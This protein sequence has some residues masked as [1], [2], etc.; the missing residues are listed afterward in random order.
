[1]CT[2]ITCVYPEKARIRELLHPSTATLLVDFSTA[3]G[4]SSVIFGALAGHHTGSI[5]IKR[6]HV[7]VVHTHKQNDQ[8][9]LRQCRPRNGFSAAQTSYTMSACS[10]HWEA[11]VHISLEQR[12]LTEIQDV[13]PYG[14]RAWKLAWATVASERDILY[15]AQ[16]LLRN[17]GNRQALS[18]TS[19][20]KLPPIS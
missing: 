10:G 6:W 17:T 11:L 20:H 12:S 5:C 1:M 3:S 15:T 18:H 7:R 9:F 16:V 14:Q 19:T 13:M 2:C 8:T 4:L